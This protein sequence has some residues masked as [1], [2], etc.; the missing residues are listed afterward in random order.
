MRTSTFNRGL[1]GL[2]TLVA[3]VLALVSAT[4]AHARETRIVGGSAA[5]LSSWPWIARV[6]VDNPGVVN[7]CT[8]TVVAPDVVLTAGHCASKASRFH[9]I[10]GTNGMSGGQTSRVSLVLREP[11][12]RVIDPGG[13]NLTDHDVALLKLTTPTTA[14]AVMLASPVDSSLYRAGIRHSVAGWGWQTYSGQTNSQTLQ[15]TTMTLL[16]QSRCRSASEAAFGRRLDTAD[17]VCAL[18][19]TGTTGICEGDSGGPLMA[20]AA[21]GGHVEIGLT[22]WNSGQCTTHAPDYFTNLAAVSGWLTQEICS[23]SDGAEMSGGPGACA[24]TYAG[25]TRQDRAVALTVG[26]SHTQ[27]SDASV[28]VELHCTRLVAPLS[29]TAHPIGARYWPRRI[30]TGEGLTFADSFRG[31]TGWRVVLRAT[32]TNRGT[33]QG[34]ASVSGHTQRYGTCHSGVVRWAVKLD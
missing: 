2:I 31:P 8:G 27:V 33:A 3:A 6:L 11:G 13:A 28:T 16:D 5:T 23:L 14:P 20:T 30:A 25:K 17:Q 22:I 15:T 18:S 29:Y 4:P 1:S 34:T 10:T 19:P 26:P 21:D 32:F 7:T 24:G 12:F 9:V